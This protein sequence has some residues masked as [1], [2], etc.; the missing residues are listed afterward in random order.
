M[1]VKCKSK[2]IFG[3]LPCTL[4]CNKQGTKIVRQLFLGK[5]DSKLVTILVLPLAY[6]LRDP[7][8]VNIIEQIVNT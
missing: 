8:T 4:L 1:R 5:T 6:R 2:Y 3:Y 7:R